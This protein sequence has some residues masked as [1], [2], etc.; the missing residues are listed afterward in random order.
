[1]FVTNQK[2]ICVIGAGASGL[3]A[4]KQCLHQNFHVCFFDKNDSLGGLWR[5]REKTINGVASGPKITIITSLKEISA[6]SDFPPLNEYPNFMDSSKMYQ[7]FELFATYFDL[8]RHIRYKN[9]VRN[10]APNDDYEETGKWKVTIFNGDENKLFEREFDGVMVCVG[11]HSKPYIPKF[12][13]QDLFNGKILHTCSFKTAKDFEDKVA[14]V[15]GIRNSGAD[16]A[17]DFSN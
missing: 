1:M 13:D 16:A 3:A 4:I 10:I 8:L 6:F 5:Y 2:Q 11:H 15:V 14:V 17:A 9:T 7:Y 12:P